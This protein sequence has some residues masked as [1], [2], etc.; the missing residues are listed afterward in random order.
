M[1]S[2]YRSSASKGK[3]IVTYHSEQPRK[4]IKAPALDTSALIK[5][6]A[7]TLIGRVTNPSE[8]PIADVISV[9]P[10]EWPIKGKVVGS[11]LG[12]GTFQFRFELEE[13]MKDVLV[14]RPYRFARWMLILQHWE[15]VISPTFPSQIPFWI[16][17]NGLPLHY[18]HQKMIYNIGQ[19]LGT[20]DDYKISTTSA[21]MQVSLNGLKPLTK[22]ALI[23]FDTGE[24]LHVTLEYEGLDLHC[25]L[26]NELSHLAKDCPQAPPGDRIPTY[27]GEE[28][29]E[30]RSNRPQ[31]QR[32][33][34]TGERPPKETQRHRPTAPSKSLPF[35]ER[36][37]RH[38]RP[39]GARLPPPANRAPPLKNR[40]TQ[41]QEL[42]KGRLE[43]NPRRQPQSS[44]SPQNPRDNY[45]QDHH[46][47]RNPVNQTPNY[48]W[49]E[50][51][52][53]M[54]Q[55]PPL[56]VTEEPEVSSKHRASSPRPPLGRNL[57]LTDFPPQPNIPTTEEVM[58]E[59]REVTYQ[60]T[61]VDDPT[62]RAARI[63]RVLQGEE[64]GLMAST[65]AR[66][67]AAAT[68]N[69]TAR[70]EQS[71]SPPLP[72][73]AP[74]QGTQLEVPPLDIPESSNARSNRTR[75]STHRRTGASPRVWAG[76]NSRL[77]NLMRTQAS[78]AR[79]GF[80]HASPIKSKLPNNETLT[81]RHSTT[82]TSA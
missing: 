6:N 24:E 79:H 51:Q 78:P 49:R 59:L 61:N 10:E 64:Q 29:I 42:G 47:A 50:H 73:E 23:D 38:G 30:Y 27:R 48:Q 60:Y 66:I 2:F 18:W 43:E 20:L 72:I 58:T 15:P 19:D 69:L 32:Q 82:T 81:R 1:A 68:S 52:P 3:S 75:Q 26:C 80:P 21:T 40:V 77:R 39:F 76:A 62:E 22:E 17:L 14:A 34:A 67:V 11:D 12:H 54:D 70:P 8:Q 65:A 37:N 36:M 5:E 9:L 7:L 13:D 57:A 46:S 28:D 71:P 53:T 74:L 41:Q 35:H 55:R 63:Q 44:K 4:R 56:A 16:R 31:T 25:L 45:P 33:L